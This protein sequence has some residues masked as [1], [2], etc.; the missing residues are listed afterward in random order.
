MFMNRRDAG[1]K[2]ASIMHAY[3]GMSDTIVLGMPDGGVPVAYELAKVLFLPLDIFCVRKLDAPNNSGVTVGAL[4]SGDTVMVNHPLAAY[5]GVSDEQIEDVIKNES[6]ELSRSEDI[7][8]RGRPAHNLEGKQVIL[9]DDG[10][11]TGTSMRAAAVA[12]R[13]F[14]PSR[15]IA[16]VPVASRE[17][18]GE[19]Q[20]FVDEV[21]CLATP[22]PFGKVS[23]WYVDFAKTEESEVQFLL[24]AAERG[25]LAA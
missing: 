3:R 18:F 9:V 24:D 5:L 21:F 7:L 16:A 4:A 1:V 11:D 15:V 8:R 10:L 6:R 17:S 23:D 12:V 19:F 22:S 20:N 2:L 25:G 14:S 13:S